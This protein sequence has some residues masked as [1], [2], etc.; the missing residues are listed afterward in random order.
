MPIP[1]I[2]IVA[3]GA[4]AYLLLSGGKKE[5]VK[6]DGSSSVK[7]AP[8]GK[9]TTTVPTPDGKGYKLTTDPQT[10]ASIMATAAE[11]DSLKLRTLETILYNQGKKEEAKACEYLAQIID[12]KKAKKAGK[13]P[14]ALTTI[15]AELAAEVLK[16]AVSGDP[17]AMRVLAAKLRALGYPEQAASWEEAATIAEAAA[18]QSKAPPIPRPPETPVV[19]EEPKVDVRP[20][21]PKMPAPKPASKPVPA[22]PLPKPAKKVKTSTPPMK[23]PAK[24]TARRLA[25]DALVK[26]LAV[27]QPGPRKESTGLISAYQSAIGVKADGKYGPGTARTLA[28]PESGEYVPPP[29]RMWPV[30]TYAQAVKDYEAWLLM[31]KAADGARAAEWQAAYEH[32]R[33]FW[34]SQ[35]KRNPR[36]NAAAVVIPFSAGRL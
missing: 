8:K 5:P 14:Q 12:A 6:K 34:P 36:P 29:P 18:K 24:P 25:A 21:T 1:L 23:Q 30:A 2:P 13:A 11:N 7:A 10:L 9:V 15:P 31:K 26:H 16:V 28:E 33:D 19:H 17:K 32:A 35:D 3:A 22:K 27:D 20:P 4:A